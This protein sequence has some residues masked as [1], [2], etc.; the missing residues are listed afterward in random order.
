MDLQGSQTSHIVCLSIA[1]RMNTVGLFL[2]H[3]LPTI[4]IPIFLKH[5]LSS[6]V[7]MTNNAAVASATKSSGVA[8]TR[9]KTT[10]GGWFQAN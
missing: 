3:G 8:A 9:R 4:M 7:I 10:V 1:D 5:I 6:G 2:L